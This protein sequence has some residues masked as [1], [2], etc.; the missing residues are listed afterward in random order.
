M[1]SSF[2]KFHLERHP[3]CRWDA[4]SIY[5]GESIGWSQLIGRYCGYSLPPDVISSGNSIV[6]NFV[7]DS[8]VT[9]EG[10]VASYISVYGTSASSSSLAHARNHS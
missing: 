3:H 6:V 1:S 2:Q 8:S 7:T 5:N 4:V 9:R 10:F